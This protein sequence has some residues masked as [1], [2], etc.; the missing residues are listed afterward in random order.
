M[1]PTTVPARD[2]AAE[3]YFNYIDLVP[4]GDIYATLDR[5]RADVNEMLATIPEHK[6]HY[7]YAPGKWSVCETLCHLNDTERV[8][9]FRALWFARGLDSPLPSFDQTVAVNGAAAE[10]RSW[11]SHLDEFDA[12]R[13]STLHL[14]GHLPPDAW[15]RAGRASDNPF[16]V[17]AIAYIIAGHTAHHVAILRE[18]YLIEA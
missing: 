11:Q 9:Q 1:H 7:R 12:I 13:V 8:F 5:Q 18:R 14:F 6:V 4:A 10:S 15:M 3:Y 17:R 16:T 2:E